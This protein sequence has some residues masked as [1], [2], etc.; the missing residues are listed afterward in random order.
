MAY[1]K[2]KPVVMIGKD[3]SMLGYFENGVPE[4]SEILRSKRSNIYHAIKFG[5]FHKGKKWMYEEDYRKFYFQMRTE[6]LSYSFKQW[7]SDKAHKIWESMTEDSRE[8]RGKKISETL[9]Q[10]IAEGKDYQKR[11]A[12]ARRK[13]VLC[14]TTGETFPSLMDFCERYSTH[15]ANASRAA[16]NGT[17]IK[18]VV[19]TY[20]K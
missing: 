8:R 4:A 19:I 16:K 7:K 15:Q 3:G 9:K 20:I 18:G 1:T 2:R 6:D 11:A 14:V 10:H 5:K 13:P 17:R 12:L